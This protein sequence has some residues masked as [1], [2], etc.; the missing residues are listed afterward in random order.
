MAMHR[1]TLYDLVNALNGPNALGGVVTPREE[2][3]QKAPKSERA[4]VQPARRAL[5]Q[6][7]RGD[8]EIEQ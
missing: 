4:D 8:E 6:D 3:R 2:E 5:V 1:A 7:G